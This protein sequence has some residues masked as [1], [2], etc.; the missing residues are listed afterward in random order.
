MF[1]ERLKELRKASKM[2]QKQLAEL[3][4]VDQTS[5]RYWETGKTKP[6]FDQQIELAK[7][8]HVSL[9]YLL[10]LPDIKKAPTSEEMDA[11]TPK[12][13]RIIELMGQMTSEQQDDLLRQA[14]YQ[15]WLKQQDTPDL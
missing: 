7:L 9:D 11:L 4:F 13:R 12:Q 10:G 1:P 2:T 5:V 3:L 15:L 8:F 14:Q 6:D